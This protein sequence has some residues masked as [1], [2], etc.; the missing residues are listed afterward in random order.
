MAGNLKIVQES[1]T[2]RQHVRVEIPARVRIGSD[3]YKVKDMSAGGISIFADEDVTKH[4]P[5]NIKILFPFNAYAF[6]L[7]IKAQ[8]VDYNRDKKIASLKFIEMNAS[9]ASLINYI[10]K[11]YMTGSL[12]TEGDLINIATRD[13]TVKIK[14]P[15]DEEDRSLKAILKRVLPTALIAMA[16]IAGL[17]F[18]AGNVYENS[19]VMK[20]YHGLIESEKIDIR[21]FSEGTVTVLIPEETEKVTKGQPLAVI[22]KER[23]ITQAALQTSDAS[24]GSTVFSPCDCH[25]LLRH[26]QTGEFRTFG[27]SLFT[28][29]PVESK[30]WVTSLIEP[31]KAHHLRLQ[32]DANI[33]IAGESGFM[34]GHIMEITSDGLDKPYTKILVKPEE[35]MPL[36]MLGRPAYV[37]F[38]QH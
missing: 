16:G 12:V 38:L 9:Q 17:L 26:V 31:K 8:L 28:L 11:S 5:G 32:G 34:A 29:V 21:S 37:E 13:N 14:S 10:L 4:T 19:L 36:E 15:Y 22:E 2:Q 25:V 27:E 20:S 18:F 7:E 24:K 1:E 3:L 35:I 33:R 23:N 30:L 6:H